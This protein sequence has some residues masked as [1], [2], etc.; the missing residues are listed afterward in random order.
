MTEETT[1]T[2]EETP[3]PTVKE[4]KAAF[5]EL[6]DADAPVAAAEA[7]LETAIADRAGVLA[8]VHALVGSDQFRRKDTKQLFRIVKRGDSYFI[9]YAK[10][11]TDVSSV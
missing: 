1:T 11:P 2:T 7:A 5:A 6:W 4:L 10:T 3:A 8:K 9:R